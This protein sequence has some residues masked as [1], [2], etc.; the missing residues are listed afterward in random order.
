[1]AGELRC[2]RWGVCRNV[3]KCYRCWAD[4]KEHCIN[5]ITEFFTS[6]N[7]RDYRQRHYKHFELRAVKKWARQ[8]PGHLHPLISYAE[9][10]RAAVVCSLRCCPWM[11][12][13]N[14]SMHDVKQLA[15]CAHDTKQLALPKRTPTAEFSCCRLLSPV[16]ML[17]RTTSCI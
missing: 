4:P 8:V 2:V 13:K 7:L 6:G 15:R 11:A 17:P 16:I 1:M 9:L 5:L 3:I 10:Y 14:V 12:L